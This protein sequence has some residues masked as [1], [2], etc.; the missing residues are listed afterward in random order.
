MSDLVAYV[1]KNHIE[2]VNLQDTRVAAG[3]AS[4]TT[5]RLL[6][7]D[8][9]QAEGLLTRLVKDVRSSGLFAAKPR[10][11]MQPLEMTE[12]GLSMVEE[13]IFLELGAGA[14][15]RRVKVH[16]GERLSAQA[17]AVVLDSRV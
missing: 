1:R 17:A 16:I 9:V 14:G 12:G 6:V 5:T 10:L 3:S 13:R 15:A 11:I 2:V 4:F 7:G 8:F